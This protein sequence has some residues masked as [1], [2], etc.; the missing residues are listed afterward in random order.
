MGNLEDG[1]GRKYAFMQGRSVS[2]ICPVWPGYPHRKFEHRTMWYMDMY[3]SEHGK[4]GVMTQETYPLKNLTIRGRQFPAPGDPLRY[5]LANYGT[6]WRTPSGARSRTEV[7]AAA[8]AQRVKALRASPKGSATA[9]ATHK[10]FLSCA[11]P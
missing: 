4:S 10:R 6:D 5:V 2:R 3:P 11:A 8:L 7:T 1:P 9:N